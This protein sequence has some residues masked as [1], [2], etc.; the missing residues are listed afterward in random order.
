MFRSI[1]LAGCLLAV[2]LAPAAWAEDTADLTIQVQN[3]L[4]SGGI[5]RLGLYNQALYPDEDAKPIASAD[6]PAIEDETDVTL[7][8][9]APGT[10]AIETFQDVNS[11]NKMDTSLLGLPKEPKP[12]KV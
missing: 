1:C 7:H 12:Q 3:V 6:V 4:P 8:G 11:N 10:Y 2:W 9:I 5:I